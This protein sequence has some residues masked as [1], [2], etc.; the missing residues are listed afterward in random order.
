MIPARD[1]RDGSTTGEERRAVARRLVGETLVEA[2][3]PV[4]VIGEDRFLTVLAGEHRRTLPVL[5]H[6]DERSL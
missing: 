5:L 4:A 2:D 1:A 6:V 3:L